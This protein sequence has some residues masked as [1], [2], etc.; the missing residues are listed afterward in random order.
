MVDRVECVLGCQEKVKMERIHIN[1][2]QE[3]P[4]G[5]GAGVSCAQRRPE[6]G[7][8]H[9][10]SHICDRHNDS[11]TGGYLSDESGCETSPCP[12]E[13]GPAESGVSWFR[14][15][16]GR[17]LPPHLQCDHNPDCLHGEDE[18]N[19]SIPAACQDGEWRCESGQCIPDSARCDLA[20]QCLDKSDEIACGV[21]ACEEGSRRCVGGQCIPA[22]LWCDWKPDCPDGSDERDCVR[23]PCGEGQ[24]RCSSGQ[25]IS[26][27]YLCDASATHRLAC[28]DHSHLLNCSEHVCG[29]GLW[30][31]DSGPCLPPSHLCDGQVQCP[32]TWDDEDHCPFS[33]SSSAPQCE[34]RDISI[35]CQR[36]GLTRLP[37]D[38]EPQISRLYTT[39]AIDNTSPKEKKA[40][41][42]KRYR[43][44][45][46]KAASFH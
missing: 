18:A 39:I 3:V 2:C 19:C 7:P 5:G 13:G 26:S 25:C 35:K 28:A 33:C 42:R 30:K 40:R 34:C 9:L 44:N 6:A 36:L 43:Q 31:C 46:R 37:R 14:C 32:L 27:V 23:A 17:C 8:L 21:E 12:G 10:R 15:T 22:A 20:F 29:P 16:D 11:H 38:I 1:R 45:K 24:F 41:K 4:G